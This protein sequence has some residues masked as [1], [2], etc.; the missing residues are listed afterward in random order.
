MGEAAGMNRRAFFAALASGVAFLRRKR[1]APIQF[2]MLK[3]GDVLE[4][5]FTARHTPEFLIDAHPG[6]G[7]PYYQVQGPSQWK[8]LDRA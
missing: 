1:V 5:K 6:I 7:I 4:V 8:G 3:A 2:P